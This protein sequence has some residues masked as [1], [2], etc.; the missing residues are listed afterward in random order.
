MLMHETITRVGSVSLKQSRSD[1]LVA[2]AMI[3]ASNSPQDTDHLKR[4]EF[5]S[6]E[7]NTMRLHEPPWPVE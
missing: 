7:V 3:A 5:R 6:G 2:A 4:N 1:C